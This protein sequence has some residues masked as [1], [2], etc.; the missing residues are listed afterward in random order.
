MIG[1]DEGVGLTLHRL[2]IGSIV[3]ACLFLCLICIIGSTFGYLT[4]QRNKRTSGYRIMGRDGGCQHRPVRRGVEE[5]DKKI[6]R[7]L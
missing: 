1:G 3:A 2:L 4:H 5:T 7:L 6:N